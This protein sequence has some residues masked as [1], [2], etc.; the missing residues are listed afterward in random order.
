M[1]PIPNKNAAGESLMMEDSVVV[2]FKG[3]KH[4]P[5]H[6]GTGEKNRLERQYRQPVQRKVP[7]LLHVRRSRHGSVRGGQIFV[8]METLHRRRRPAPGRTPRLFRVCQSVFLRCWFWRPLCWGRGAVARG[9]G[10]LCPKSLLRVG[11]SMEVRQLNPLADY[12]YGVLAMLAT[13]DSLVRFGP[14]L[15][16]ITPAGGVLG[17]VPGLPLLAFSSAR[18]RPLARR[19]RR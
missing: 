1:T 18:R 14:D 13:H 15:E 2:D 16:P 19:P 6:W 7:L 8:L 12:Q 4:C 5:V 3:T 17:G 10:S 11:T 9:P